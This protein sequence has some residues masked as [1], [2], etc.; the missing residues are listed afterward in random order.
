MSEVELV[1]VG[2]RAS[3]SESGK[4]VGRIEKLTVACL[5][6]RLGRGNT[7]T[8]NIRGGGGGKGNNTAISRQRYCSSVGRKSGMNI[9]G[10]ARIPYHGRG[11]SHIRGVPQEVRQNE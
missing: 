6:V 11:R 7:P 1:R 2:E 5:A 10:G 8:E 4:K 3:V 9:H